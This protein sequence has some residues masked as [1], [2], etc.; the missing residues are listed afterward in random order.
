MPNN[1]N[2]KFLK[3]DKNCFRLR[4]QTSSRTSDRSNSQGK[5]THTSFV[6][7]IRELLKVTGTTGLTPASDETE[8]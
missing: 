1:I 5:Q 6:E 2:E 4:W 3:G 8:R 7:D